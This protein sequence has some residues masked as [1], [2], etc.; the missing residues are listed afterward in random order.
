[1]NKYR[2]KSAK[3]LTVLAINL[4]AFLLSKHLIIFFDQIIQK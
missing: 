1:M 4:E 2:E 3:V